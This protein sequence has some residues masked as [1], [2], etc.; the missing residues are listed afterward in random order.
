MPIWSK[1]I[2]LEYMIPY[3]GELYSY[4]VVVFIYPDKMFISE[5]GGAKK[6]YESK[7]SAVLLAFSSIRR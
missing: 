5:A 4:A 6:Y 7:R 1:G 2:Y 3:N